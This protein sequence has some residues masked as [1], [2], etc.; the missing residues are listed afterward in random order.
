[1]LTDKNVSYLVDSN[2]YYIL[3]LGCLMSDSQLHGPKCLRHTTA[4]GKQEGR[5][6]GRA[7]P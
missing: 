1:M 3:Q 6:H 7:L 5:I 2:W 4:Q